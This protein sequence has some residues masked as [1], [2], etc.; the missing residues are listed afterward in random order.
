M[1]DDGRRFDTAVYVTAFDARHHRYDDEILY[2]DA[3]IRQAADHSL[4]GPSY[5]LRVALTDDPDGEQFDAWE[6]YGPQVT[7][8]DLLIVSG[9]QA[10][11]APDDGALTGKFGAVRWMQVPYTRVLRA[12]AGRQATFEQIERDVSAEDRKR[13]MALWAAIKAEREQRP[14]AVARV[15]IIDGQPIEILGTVITAQDADRLIEAGLLMVSVRA[16][17]RGEVRNL[18]LTHDSMQ[19]VQQTGQR[20]DAIR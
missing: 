14:G 7:L 3:Q 1:S 20:R 16:D 19:W 11:R 18:S 17:H 13:I 2:R 9:F 5:Q 10:E 15:E 6:I 12:D 8:H 4:L